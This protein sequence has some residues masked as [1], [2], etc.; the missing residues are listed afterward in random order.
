[1]LRELITFEVEGQVFGLD[2]MAIREIRAWSPT[3]RLPRVPHYVAGVVNLRGTVLPVVD[4]A[5]RLGWRATEATPRHAIIVTQQGAQISGWIV[6]S[7]SDIV[8]ID[9]EALQ[10][11]PPTSAGDTV[12]PFLEGLA[13]IEDRMVMV[14]NLA[15]LSDGAQ[16]Q[17]ARR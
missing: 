13:A 11:P 16:I 2:I 12:V 1:M 15:A 17:P 14:L 6:D 8:T 3:T 4:L 5:A 7:V 9:S 10:P